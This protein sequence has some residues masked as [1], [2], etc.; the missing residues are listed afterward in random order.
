VSE[1]SDLPDHAQPPVAVVT[2]AA[3]RRGIGRA[4]ARRLAGSGWSVAL[5]DIEADQLEATAS[6]LR[7]ETGSQVVAARADVGSEPEVEA[8]AQ[9]IERSLP[10]VVAL[11]NAAGISDPTPLL[12]TSLEQWE[13]IQRV[14]STSTFLLSRRFAPGMRDR[15]YG[16]IVNLSST[17][18]LTGGGTYSAGAYAASKAAIEGFT[19][20]L[21]LEVAR[22][23]VTVNAVSPAIIDTD[24][25]GGP[26]TPHR[27]PNFVSSL[28]VGRLG[29]VDEVAA[30][31][32]F[33][34]GRDAGYITGA[35]YA[36]NG[37]VRIG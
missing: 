37:G 23:G 5:V 1:T 8:A 15:R 9:L 17:A 21:A 25:M 28:P 14:N 4:V 10:P 22:H 33:L 26:I 18:A 6:D 13:R 34:V 27:A 12:E 11:V 20:G 35:T 24:I 30:L 19:H 31:I 32:E 3:S 16:R 36:I 2:G 29:R 7:A